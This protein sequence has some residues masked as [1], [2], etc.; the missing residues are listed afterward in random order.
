MVQFLGSTS[1]DGLPNFAEFI[2]GTNPHVADNPLNLSG[3]TNGTQVSGFAQ[4]PII[5]LNPTFKTFPIILYVNGSPAQNALLSQAPDRQWLMNWDTTFLTNGNYQVQLGCQINPPTLPDSFTNILGLQKTVQVNNPLTFDRLT[6]KFTDFLLI[7]ATLAVTNSTYDI[8]LYDDSGNPLVY[9]TGLSAPDGQIALYWDLTDGYGDQISFGNI[10]AVFNIYPATNPNGVHPNTPP[11]SSSASQWFL[12]DTPNIDA[13]MFAVAWGWD[14]YL[15]AFNNYRTELM[16]DGVINILGNPSDFSSYTLLPAV[17]S[18]YGGSAFRY[19]SELDRS[20]LIGP[21]RHGMGDL[22]KSGNFF[23]FGHGGEI[24]DDFICGNPD[25]SNITANDVENDLQN[26]A[27]RSTPKVPTTNKHPYRLTILDTCDSYTPGWAGAFGA[28]F[29]A[30]GSSDS[31]ADYAYVGRPQR[32]FVGWT[33]KIG[34]PGGNDLFFGGLLDA[35]YAQ[36]LGML[37]GSWMEGYPLDYCMNQFTTT[38]LNA[39][40]YYF[41]NAYAWKISGCHDLT[42]DDQ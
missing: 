23:W 38:A 27:F 10:Q 16:Q 25:R 33:K 36:A 39:E 37:F 9:V 20:V 34:V 18:P 35:E 40:P 8:Y 29:S 26:K 1:N 15:T 7:Y 13:N 22:G 28:D 24:N 41:Q 17:N 21:S 31:A 3:V 32:A 42:K 12:K 11:S 6:S 4:L 5:G 19:D 2:L 30:N 14:N